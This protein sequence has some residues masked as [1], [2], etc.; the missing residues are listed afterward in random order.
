MTP[1]TSSAAAPGDGRIASIASTA[2]AAVCR[3]LRFVAT[4]ALA[5]LGFIVLMP[6]ATAWILIGCIMLMFI[7]PD[8]GGVIL[9]GIIALG[10]GEGRAF[11]IEGSGLRVDYEL[12]REATEDGANQINPFMS[13]WRFY[14]WASLVLYIVGTALAAVRPPRPRRTLG[15]KLR[16]VVQL[17]TGA[18]AALCL[19]LFVRGGQT[20]AGNIGDWVPHFTLMV[21][22]LLVTGLFTVTVRHW[23][24]SLI[25]W[26]N[27]DSKEPEV[28]TSMR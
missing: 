9:G 6:M 27:G 25:V 18:F 17:S 23:M 19:I 28:V 15:F 11:F 8:L 10:S 4:Q 22:T 20:M 12:G 14:V 24:E 26:L 2:G 21:V 7:W 13:I 5:Y 16:R 3:V 1:G